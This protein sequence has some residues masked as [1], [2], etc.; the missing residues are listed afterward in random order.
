MNEIFLWLLG[1]IGAGVLAILGWVANVLTRLPVEYVP[2]SQVNE[3]F[4]KIQAHMDESLRSMERDMEAAEV[5][6]DK[7]FDRVD[8]NLER[9][10]N[11][12]DGKADK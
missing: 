8:A 3:R 4:E 1:V 9:I 7:R 10:L 6:S 5:R 11:K 12:L 2:R